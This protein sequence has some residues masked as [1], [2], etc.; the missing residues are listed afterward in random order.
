M[1]PYHLQPDE[2]TKLTVYK[3]NNSLI[4]L[5]RLTIKGQLKKVPDLPCSLSQQRKTVL[6]DINNDRYHHGNYHENR[7]FSL[8][9]LDLTCNQFELI[10]INLPPHET[11]VTVNSILNCIPFRSTSSLGKAKYRGLVD[12]KKVDMINR[13]INL[14]ENV[15]LKARDIYVPIPLGSDIDECV[16]ASHFIINS[17]KSSK[18]RNLVGIS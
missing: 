1:L 4:E 7:S 18:L 16:R 14:E 12:L 6:V 15:M 9:L 10:E 8:L 11:D 17:P 2:V 3:Q 13:E 5:I